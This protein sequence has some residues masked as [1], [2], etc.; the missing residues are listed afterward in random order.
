MLIWKTINANPG[1]TRDEIFVKIEDQIPAGWA[2]RRYINVEKIH[3]DDASSTWILRR[4][5]RYILR[6]TLDQMRKHGSVNRDDSGGHTVLR[7]IRRY[8]GNPDHVD[9]TGQIAADHLNEA[10]AW[11]KL[12]AA[13]KRFK[14]DSPRLC[15]TRVEARAFALIMDARRPAGV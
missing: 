8:N 3:V 7:E 9:H 12:Q 4:S 6:D 5:R 1:I 13:R 2:T 14:P 11:R 15:L 10:Y